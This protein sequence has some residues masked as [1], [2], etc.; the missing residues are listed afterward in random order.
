MGGKLFERTSRR[1]W[2]TPLGETFRRGVE[3][4]SIALT[5]TL[6]ECRRLARGDMRRL[7]IGFLGG[8]LY[9]LTSFKNV[10]FSGGLV[11]L[12][13]GIEFSGGEVSFE[14]PRAWDKPPRVPW[15]DGEEPPPYVH[16]RHWPPKPDGQGGSGGGVK[17][18]TQV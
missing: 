8:G 9:E 4:A 17:A 12:H 5:A 2:L 18:R 7:R 14:S 6:D 16:P 3:P 1:V 11:L 13:W 15:K 10:S